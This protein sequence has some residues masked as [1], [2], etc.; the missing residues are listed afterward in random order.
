MEPSSIA[1][2]PLVE[3]RMCPAGS[4]PLDDV[5][6]TRR[7]ANVGD[8]KQENVEAPYF[9]SDNAVGITAK[10]YF[11]TV[12]GVRENSIRSMI[13][14]VAG[15]I[16]DEGVRHGYFKTN[17]D[18]TEGRPIWS[19]DT[20]TFYNELCYLLVNQ[21]AAFNTP[22][23][24]NVGVPGRK[25]VCS[26][27]FLLSVEDTMHGAHSITDWWSTE[28]KIFKGGAGSGVNVSKLRG[29]ME[30]LSTGG[31]ASGPLSYMRVADVG[32]GTLKSG[33]AHR[34]AAKMVIL[35]ASHPDIRDFI[36]GKRR[37]DKRMRDLAAAGYEVN[38][39]TA[40]GEKFIAESTSSQN[41]NHSVAVT[42]EFM[43]LATASPTALARIGSS[44][45]W[46][47]LARTTGEVVEA[48]DAREILDD[49][50]DAAWRCADPGVIFIDTVNQWHTTPVLRGNPSPISTCNPCA[51][52]WLNDDSSCNLASLNL[53]K[54][55]HPEADTFLIGEF[56]HAIDVMTLAMDI[57]C[58]FSELPT[59]EIERNTRE[60]R[61]LGLGYSNLGATLMALGKPYDSDEAR[62]WAASV[63]A[64]MTGRAYRRSAELAERM[65]AYERYAENEAAHQGVIDKHFNAILV[66]S[67]IWSAAA[68]DWAEAKRVGMEYGYR[69]SQA[70]VLAP[71][72]TISYLMGCDTT[73]IE[74]AFDLFTHKG[75]AGGGSMTL[76]I[77]AAERAARLLGG[78]SDDN[79]KSM[80]SGDFSCISPEDQE[81]FATANEI[82][83]FG[84]IA[85][86]AAVQPFLSGAPSKTINL[87]ETATRDDIREIIVHAWRSGC[88]ATSVYR[89][90]SKATQVLTSKPKP[91]PKKI[92]S[93]V[94]TG[95][96]LVEKIE[97]GEDPLPDYSSVKLAPEV[98]PVRYRLPATRQSITHKFKIGEYEGYITAGMY[99]DG[100]LGEFFLTDVGKE[101]SF[102]QGM[103]G[104]WSISCS[105]DF[106]YGV[107]L[108]ALARKFIGM[109]FAPTGHTGNP[110]IPYARSIPDYLFKWLVARFCDADTCEELGVRTDAVKERQIARLDGQDVPIAPALASSNGHAPT[111]S[112]TPCPECGGLVVPTGN[113]S[114][115]P[116]CGW[117]GGCG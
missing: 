72:G 7:T 113:C 21:M 20:F 81:V 37:E 3:A 48:D 112:P 35:D 82:S 110:E 64:L 77:R 25:Q 111:P 65:G 101:G 90:G 34:R 76:V 68:Y 104:A 5:T 50:A 58:S 61:Q 106:Q 117:N 41:A 32:A 62:D 73:G 31:V 96:E 9:W 18:E 14:R 83:P 70:T 46:D 66:G 4:S 29:S 22:V 86:V 53:M 69:N 103:M 10:L 67:D 71:T 40:S 79:L 16:A 26:A 115:C 95:E 60:L 56:Q 6:W 59:L 102:A 98:E 30:R 49:I 36:D 92:A 55:I 28:A 24:L 105:V 97:R 93:L 47:L 43:W 100:K 116:N 91:T 8:F 17:G 39:F 33:G 13:E 51:E 63:T 84:H 45:S 88:K 114:T 2:S 23:W 57:T 94:P 19:P 74:P 38:P 75:L 89:N 107:P 99:E 109:E 27:C 108:E 11:A 12:N 85:M 42:D 54:F 1:R 78:Y 15:R 52:T 44:S 80:A 87:A